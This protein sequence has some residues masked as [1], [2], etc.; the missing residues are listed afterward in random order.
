MAELDELIT[1]K[2]VLKKLLN[3]EKAKISMIQQPD[4]QQ[5]LTSAS[6]NEN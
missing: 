5:T 1:I 3:I 6:D 4:L 2:K